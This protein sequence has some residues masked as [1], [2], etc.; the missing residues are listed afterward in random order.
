MYALFLGLAVIQQLID[1]GLTSSPSMRDQVFQFGE[2]IHVDTD[3]GI[4]P[5][6][7]LPHIPATKTEV[8]AVH[9]QCLTSF[10]HYFV[11]QTQQAPSLR[12]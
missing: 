5:A 12:R 7:L 10:R 1:E 3:L 11:D 4:T 2:S 6:G 9:L 8:T